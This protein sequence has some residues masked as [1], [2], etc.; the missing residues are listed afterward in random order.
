M[1]FS[2]DHVEKCH[3]RRMRQTC[4]H[5]AGYAVSWPALLVISLVI[6]GELCRCE[7]LSSFG[8][9]QIKIVQ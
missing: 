4:C 1:F 5:G 6:V 3:G 8:P 7:E 9:G 2:K